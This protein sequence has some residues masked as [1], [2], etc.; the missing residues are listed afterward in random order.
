MIKFLLLIIART[1]QVVLSPI[2]IVWGVVQSL[3]KG[4][5]LQ[6][7]YELAI[8]ID[9]FGNCL[10]KYTF[11][12]ILGEGFGNSKETISSRLGRNKIN[13]TLKPFGK[14]VANTLDTLDTNHCI[15][16]IDTNI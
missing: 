13:N 8:A 2:L 11:N 10:G 3:R 5:Y 12:D 7:S 14:V 15:K 1:I 9:R 4:E 16:S 6:W